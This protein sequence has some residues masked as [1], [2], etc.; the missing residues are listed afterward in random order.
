MRNVAPG[1]LMR[2]H[3]CRLFVLPW[4]P[5]A[6]PGAL[7][8]CTPTSSAIACTPSRR[9]CARSVPQT[10]PC[11]NRAKQESP[12]ESGIMSGTGWIITSSI[13]Y[14]VLLFTIAILTFRKG[15]WILGLLGFVFPVL[16]LIG[17]ILPSRRAYR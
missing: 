10:S 3:P 12:N 13:I 17:A 4:T 15:H 2:S 8:R 11:P 7:A 16:W 1:S 14:L 5:S 9:L 6:L